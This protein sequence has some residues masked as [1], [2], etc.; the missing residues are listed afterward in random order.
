[1]VREDFIRKLGEDIADTFEIYN[2]NV[3]YN[4]VY[5]GT[6]SNGIPVEINQDVM[7]AEY[8]IAIGTMMPHSFYG[9][10]GGAKSILPGI[11]SMNTIIK[12][13][14]FTSPSEFNMGNPDTRIRKDAEEAAAMMGLDF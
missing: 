14:S 1:M 3:F 11:A 9:F 8:K 6:T 12:N 7:T 5:L 10:S 13:H 4:H 2:H